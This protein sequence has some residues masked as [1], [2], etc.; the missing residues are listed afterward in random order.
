[1]V[2][3]VTS[4]RQVH[5]IAV[6]C[7][8]A[9]VLAVLLVDHVAASQ[10]T[11]ADVPGW[12]AVAA[13]SVTALLIAVRRIWP[14]TVYV[15]VLAA[16]TFATVAGVSGNPAVTV[17]LA[18]YTVA[19]A[20]PRHRSV[21]ALGAALAL[22]LPA[23]AYAGLASHPGPTRPVLE[24]EMTVTVVVVVAG[25]LIGAMQRRY[26]AH[27]AEE[28]ARTAVTDER[29]RIAR[30]LHDIISNAMALITAKAAVTNYLMDS[31]PDDARAALTIIEET[32]RDALAEMRRLLGIL[33]AGSGSLHS[34][35]AAG[36]AEADGTPAP[37]LA[38]IQALA[39]Q[40]TAAGVPTTVEVRG[41]RNLPQAM[42]LSV[43]RIVQEAVTN[44]IKHAGPASCAIQ[45]DLTGNDV[46]VDIADNG[47]PRSAAPDQAGGHGLI[48]MRERVSLFNGQLT[49]APHPEGGFRVT[50]RLPVNPARPE[51]GSNRRTDTAL[52]VSQGPTWP[53]QRG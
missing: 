32:G 21:P 6:D 44:V 53:S 30:E 19:V 7:C 8:A 47:H 22:T 3:S 39:A 26:A 1:L 20:Q 10:E 45:I 31:R 13:S 15:I 40:A 49:A 42:A 28:Q 29:L 25:W 27:S 18:L 4:G 9:V 2:R 52:P 16:N 34:P 23:Q 17:A 38:G 43:Y 35:T 33:R 50:A 46:V 12:V 48:G 5:W 37:G 51:G 14:A 41:E 11:L 24:Y 36:Q